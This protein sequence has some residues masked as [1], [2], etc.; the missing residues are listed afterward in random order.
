MTEIK[1]HSIE[2]EGMT[3]T[4]CSNGH[5]WIFENGKGVAHFGVDKYRTDEE[6]IE[7][8]KFHMITILKYGDD[9]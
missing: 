8:A 7:Y 9:E 4:Q 2:Y 1:P 5:I 3:I 6:L